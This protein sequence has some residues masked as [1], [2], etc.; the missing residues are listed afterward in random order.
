LSNNHKKELMKRFIF[1]ISILILTMSVWVSCQPDEDV[2]NIP[3]TDV[4]LDPDSID[5]P[6]DTI[7]QPP[8]TLL[9]ELGGFGPFNIGSQWT[10][11]SFT[12]SIDDVT[13][14]VDTI[15][16]DFTV[17][18]L[19][20]TIINHKQYY[21]Y[22]G[23]RF[24]RKEGNQY[25]K[26]WY[27]SFENEWVEEKYLDLDLA[28]GATWKSDTFQ[29]PI[30]T[31]PVY[32]RYTLFIKDSTMT[33]DGITYEHVAKVGLMKMGVG[34]PD[35]MIAPQTY[36]FALGVGLIKFEEPQFMGSNAK[37]LLEYEVF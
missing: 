9:T 16:Y 21:R 30:P 28:Q 25:Y 23:G 20:D 7:V 27:N 24:Q 3:P 2:L 33:I 12:T 36:Y 19:S 15:S 31:V 32:N 11:W 26:L 29:L 17:S 5:Q 6:T 14:I 22:S 4:V 18:S 34:N 37:T 10:Y 1:A 13:G 8:D 35:N